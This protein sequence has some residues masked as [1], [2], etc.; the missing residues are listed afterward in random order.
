MLKFPTPPDAQ[1]ALQAA[2]TKTASF[3]SAALDLGN[4]FAPDEPG[5]PMAAVVTVTA[6]DGTTGDETYTF[7]LQQSADGS[8]GWTAIG[9]AASVTAIGG[10]MAKGFV[11]ARYVR[12]AMVAAGTTP[13]ITYSAHL[14][15]LI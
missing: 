13:S 14:S 8:T 6:R 15:P 4:G 12:L 9:A 3:N 1:L 11:T 10:A 2:T 7:T 5:Q